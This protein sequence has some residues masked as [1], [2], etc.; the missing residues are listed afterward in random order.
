MAGERV[1]WDYEQ[2]RQAWSSYRSGGLRWLA[3]GVACAV[4]VVVAAQLVL[5]RSQNLLDEGAATT[6]TIQSADTQTVTF[7]YDADGQTYTGTLDVVSGRDYAV[8]EQVEVRY[9]RADP[10]TA[11]LLD[12]PHRIP[13]IGPALVVLSMVAMGAVPIGIGV[14]FRAGAWG[15]AMRREPWTSARLRVRGADL[16]LLPSDSGPAVNAKMRATS[17]WRTKTVQ[18]MDGQELWILPAGARNL[19]LTADGTDTVYGLRRRD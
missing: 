8:G 5:A 16:V 15:R 19:V 4:L 11:R 3:V 12:E 10:S 6:A 18:G 9:D 13:G 14:L 17:R 2:S 7:S 1:A